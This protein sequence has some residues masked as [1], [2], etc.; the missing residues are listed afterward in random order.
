M[1]S[2]ALPAFLWAILAAADGLMTAPLPAFP[3]PHSGKPDPREAAAFQAL[4]RYWS[5]AGSRPSTA[6][7]AV[8]FRIDAELPRLHKRGVLR[9][10][11][12]ITGAGRIVYTQLHFVGDN[13]IRSAVIARF[14]S[15]DTK[16]QTGG[17]AAR[18]APDNYR[19]SY[20][21]TVDYDR[22]S[23][24]VFA[25]QPKRKVVGLFKGELWIDAETARPLRE[26]GEFV[27]SPST[28]LRH[29]YFVR[30]YASPSEDS[31]VRRIIIRLQAAFAGP[32]ELTMWM[33]QA[34]GD[35]SGER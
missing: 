25:T 29:V 26:W 12:E 18:I 33:D 5:E 11:K 4:D 24:F 15:A 19:L 21:G 9:G 30:D 14:L 31:G 27:K 34:E 35:D 32:V 23:V 28:F 16:F 6:E 2:R 20:K 1:A 3:L 8:P 13:L 7:T 17:Q 10:V 22:R